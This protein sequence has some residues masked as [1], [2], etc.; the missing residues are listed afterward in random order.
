MFLFKTS[1]KMSPHGEPVV[2]LNWFRTMVLLL[3]SCVEYH[4]YNVLECERNELMY[5]LEEIFA[6]PRCLKK[7]KISIDASSTVHEHASRN[8]KGG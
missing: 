3:H 4:R 7:I 1:P 6:S 8:T 2:C 5:V